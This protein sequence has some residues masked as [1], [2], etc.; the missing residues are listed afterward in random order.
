MSSREE[1]KETIK[2]LESDLD[3]LTDLWAACEE[4]NDGDVIV[5]SSIALQINLILGL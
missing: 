5:P 4:D 3:K 1:L 2:D